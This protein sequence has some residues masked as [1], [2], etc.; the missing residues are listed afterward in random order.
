MQMKNKNLGLTLIELLVVLT[1]IA[2]VGAVVGPRVLSQLGG[3]QTK[4]TKL[5]IDDFGAALDLF[6]LDT[7]RYPSSGE[8]LQALVAAPAG[9]EDWNGPYLKKSELPKDPWK[10]EFH[11]QSPGEH[12]EYDLYSYGKD[13]A[14]GGDDENSDIV[15]WE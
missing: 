9:S 13:G 2:L 4:T 5:Q 10:Y 3:A 11:Y 6:Y 15:S 14:P 1:I 8:G 12:G 7:G